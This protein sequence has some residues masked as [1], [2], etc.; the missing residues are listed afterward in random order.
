MEK[1]DVLVFVFI[2]VIPF[3]MAEEVANKECSVFKETADGNYYC[4]D[5]QK[6]YS[7]DSQPTSVELSQEC[8]FAKELGVLTKF[9][10]MQKEETDINDS[11]FFTTYKINNVEE[12]KITDFSI[13]WGEQ[14]GRLINKKIIL[15]DG[16]ELKTSDMNTLL[17]SSSDRVDYRIEAEF[18]YDTCDLIANYGFYDVVHC[19][20]DP[21]ISFDGNIYPEWD[22]WEQYTNVWV[23]EYVSTEKASDGDVVMSSGTSTGSFSITG[24]SD[25]TNCLNAG[26]NWTVTD[27]FSN[28]TSADRVE[29]G[30]VVY[31]T[32]DG[33]IDTSL[34][35]TH[36]ASGGDV[37]ESA[38][39]FI[40]NSQAAGEAYWFSKNYASNRSFKLYIDPQS[41][42]SWT[43][44]MYESQDGTPTKTHSSSGD[45]FIE[46]DWSSDGSSVDVYNKGVLE[47]TLTGLESQK[48]YLAFGVSPADNIMYVNNTE[49]KDGE[50][51]VEMDVCYSMD[52]ITFSS[53]DSGLVSGF[54]LTNDTSYY[55][56]WTARFNRTVVAEPTS[57]LRSMNVT[58]SRNSM[59]DSFGIEPSI[60]GADVDVYVWA[61]VSLNSKATECNYTLIAPDHELY[62]HK[63]NAT[64]N[65]DDFWN[66][67]I[68]K[69][70]VTG[71][72]TGNMTCTNNIGEGETVN[73]SFST[74]DATPPAFSLDYPI[75][76]TTYT[77]SPNLNFWANDDFNL[78]ECRYN[79]D[80][81]GNTT[82][83]CSGSGDN[84][85]NV[86]LSKA[87]GSYTLNVY[88][89]DD[90]NLE[91]GSNVSF[92]ITTP[93]AETPAGGGGG[94]RKIVLG[95]N[96]S[97]LIDFNGR[98]NF[99]FS[100]FLGSPARD[101]EFIRII[102]LGTQE[103][104]GEI[105]IEGDSS[106]Y[107]TASVCDLNKENCGTEFRLEE[108]ESAFL[109]LELIVDDPLPSD[110]IDGVLKIYDKTTKE[111]NEFIVGVGHPP[112]W[113][114]VR[115]VERIPFFDFNE[116][117]S[118]QVVGG[119]IISIFSLFMILV[120]STLA[121]GDLK[122]VRN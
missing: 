21:I 108:K 48:W 46:F 32:P 69:S 77:S 33:S 110:L 97:S 27:W 92:T 49:V 20:A 109:K 56:N 96:I 34:W 42:G 86:T 101:V 53:C 1:K 114:L 84:Y 38:T 10:L 16:T 104:N 40:A 55:M 29:G 8:L 63:E 47:T 60:P 64:V 9:R 122:D 67:T 36:T 50:S 90:A 91:N 83:A 5:D 73:I 87:D 12:K 13:D 116:R 76:G 88:A 103:I 7:C 117:Q 115:L 6:V 30:W 85:R 74:N 15:S 23:G 80:G 65:D 58:F 22:V 43:V 119:S 118:A 100:L 94:G 52:N 62:L 24:Y 17:T 72:Y 39:D 41:T 112:G 59:F 26:C 79:F 81:G 4:P 25:G 35:T 37:S 111:V 28:G 70:N 71:S 113:G 89:I 78:K 61:N 57:E 95:E 54:S 2:M 107:L 98:N 120:F 18:D 66:S 75:E 99:I 11:K 105:S 3:I 19:L 121:Y 82:V 45:G 44:G 102:N 106:E 14:K 51:W 68:V 31:D 93:A